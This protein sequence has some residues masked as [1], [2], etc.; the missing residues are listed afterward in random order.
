MSAAE[1]RSPR[2]AGPVR[3]AL[4]GLGAAARDIHGPA[5]REL[6]G[7][8]LVAG[9]DPSPQARGQAAR[10]GAGL[11]CYE[12][13]AALF[14]AER[15]DW[16]IVAA[17]PSA[18]GELCRLA[19]ARGANVFCEK[20]LTTSLA[21]A[22]ALIAAARDA[23]RVLAVNHEFPQMPIFRA[24]AEAIDGEELGRLLF[25]QATQHVEEETSE[26]AGWRA[27]GQ[28]LREFGTHVIDLA[29]RF[30]GAFPSRV[31][32]SMPRAGD[33]AASGSDLI[34]VLTLEFAD[35]R[36]ASIVLDR[37]CRGVH[38][39]LELRLDGERGSLRASIGGRAGVS[40]GLAPRSRRPALRLDWAA[41]GQAWLERGDTRRVLA[42]NPGAI[43]AHATAR[44]LE[45]TL[46][47]VATGEPLPCSAPFA[48]GI[49]AVVEAAYQSARQGRVIAIAA[50][51]T[52][53]GS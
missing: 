10:W 34:D 26:P 35:G 46:D 19:F 7:V 1:P 16:V 53:P 49:A 18:H 27:R 45:G 17:E 5:C 44:N 20:P 23:G 15:P 28:T 47:A 48:R 25:L 30:Y 39:Y 33:A 51:P 11:T 24:A 3:F 22:D 38:R 21:E 36:A 43:F 37:V 2:P 50:D 29:V 12:S 32:C 6:P 31:F 13:A 41:G 8:E 40:L 4:L 42:R 14:D 9:A 52:Q